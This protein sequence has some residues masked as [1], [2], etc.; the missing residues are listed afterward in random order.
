MTIAPTVV[1]LPSITT[2]PVQPAFDYSV[3]SVEIASRLRQQAARIRGR[4]G[5]TSQE[6]IDIG[7]DLL[8]AKE[9]VLERGQFTRWIEAEVRISVRAAQDYMAMARL[10]EAKGATVALL[11]P[12]TVQRLAAKSAPG[13]VVT[14]IV[15]RARGGEILLDNVV[16]T[17]IREARDEKRQAEREA[18]K[19]EQA[20]RRRKA[21]EAQKREWQEEKRRREQKTAEIAARLRRELGNEGL[22]VVIAAFSDHD[23]WAEDL[24]AA[25]RA[26]ATTAEA[27]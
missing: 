1:S 25:L 6:L 14:A 5:K 3:L 4:L 15:E 2:V 22:A 9:H 27:A 7:R 20:K 16:E 19:P 18:K 26:G 8:A 23:I 17:M 21:Q 13:E 12:K 11:P 10:A 24:L